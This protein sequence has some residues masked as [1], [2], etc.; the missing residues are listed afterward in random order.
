MRIEQDAP[1]Y[2]PITIVLETREE[3][4]MLAL[5]AC[6]ALGDVIAPGNAED[7]EAFLRELRNRL[8]QALR[9]PRAHI[10]ALN[11]PETKV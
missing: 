11:M 1:E 2:R 6:S 3:A 9:D 8:S 10:E 4:T 7:F 5:A